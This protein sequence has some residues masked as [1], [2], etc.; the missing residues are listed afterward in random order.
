MAL[1]GGTRLGPYEIVEPIGAGGMGEVYRARDTRLERTVAIKV[2]AQHL[3]SDLEHRQRFEREARS[4]S[5]LQHP[6]ICALHDVGSEN[7]VDYLVMEHLEGETVAQRLFRGPLPTEQVLKIGMELADALDKAHRQGVVHRDLKPG[8][9]MLT[10]SGAKLL[11]FGLA[12]PTILSA[13]SGT[14]SA[15][16][17]APSPVSPTSPVS[18]Q[19]VVVGTFQYMAPEQIQGKEA[20]PRSDIFSLGA[21]LYEM[22]T[23]RRA[24]EG[25]S[26]LSVASAILEKEPEPITVTQP[27]APVA[28]E[29]VVRV[30]LAKDPEDRWQSAAD[31]KRELKWIAEGGS[32]VAAVAVPGVRRKTRERLA[33]AVAGAMALLVVALG[34]GYMRR[35]S[36]PAPAVVKR[37]A[38]SSPVSVQL[39][40]GLTNSLAVSPDGRYFVYRASQAGGG[41]RLYLQSLSELEA[42]PIAG[43]EDASNPF[44]SPDGNWV[45]FFARGQLKKVAISGGTPLTICEASETRGASWGPDN[46]I[47]FGVA[48]TQGLRRVP[49]SGGKTEELTRVDASQKELSH[50]WPEFLPGGQEVLFAIQGLTADW[51]AARIAVLSLKT[52][53]WRTLIEGGT[54][55]HY[56]PTGHLLYARTGLLVAVPFDLDRLEVTG[57]PVPV[58]EDVLMNRASGNAHAAF[59]SEGTLVYVAGQSAEGPR[60]LVWVDRKG[61]SRPVGVTAAGF[62]QPSLSPDGKRIAVHIRPPSDDI[63]VY[64]LGRGTLTRLTFQPGEDESPVWSPDGKQVA[65]SSSHG[66]RPRAILWKN[67]DGSGTEETVSA[68]GFH[69]HL[70]AF[71]SDGRWLAYTNYESET[72]GDVWLLPLAGDRKPRPFLQTPFNENDPKISPDGRWIAYTSDETGREEIY[73]QSL[74]GPGGK[75]QISSDGGFGALWARSGRELFY[76]KDNKVL[77]VSVT[78]QPGF[79]ASSPQPLFDG[80]YDIHPRREGIWDVSPDGQRFLMVKPS[81]QQ[82]AQSQLRVVLNFFTELRRRVAEGSN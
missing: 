47:V 44:F 77:A 67:A 65:F 12:K 63:W 60:D 39:F 26:Q 28:L 51:D 17:T 36:Q 76:R 56:S 13:G 10:K 30:C 53:K 21:V 68:T 48:A 54:N 18:Q 4:I 82:P 45:A 46:T 41:W 66:D 43:S 33:W 25:K 49:A 14:L 64:D 29:H 71:S 24:F 55:P 38:V 6:N 50:R 73:V 62:E 23:G 81:G 31:V 40:G 2:L 32:S 72:R 57:P 69:I 19:G 75:Y 8:N 27:L 42:T 78:T 58:L 35:N 70:G 22:T 11:D 16:V 79:A 20:D 74:E 7:G 37:F 59:S 52:G 9:V 5:S 3:S 34:I 61:I 1:S 80:A 15:A